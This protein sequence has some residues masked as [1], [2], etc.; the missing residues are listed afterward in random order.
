MLLPGLP[1]ELVEG[2]HAFHLLP[3]KAHYADLIRSGEKIIE[4]RHYGTGIKQGDLVLLYE[5][6]PHQ[7]IRTAFIAGTTL[8]RS[9]EEMWEA[10]A[11]AACV[12]KRDFDAYFH[13][14]PVAFGI[15]IAQVH[16]LVPRVVSD[17]K[18]LWKQRW[19]AP[20]KCRRV[21]DLPIPCDWSEILTSDNSH[22][23]IHHHIVH[24]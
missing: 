5:S 4:L 9:P 18:D 11:A 24:P 6:L 2:D 19:S 1:E 21:I 23:L 13:R 16:Q 10:A 12:E 14:R 7:V 22:S 8:V 20:Y 15:R 3:I 17:M